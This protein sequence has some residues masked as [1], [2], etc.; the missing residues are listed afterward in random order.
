MRNMPDFHDKDS[1]LCERLHFPNIFN[2]I[3]KFTGLES[4]VLCSVMYV[5]GTLLF[6]ETAHTKHI[7]IK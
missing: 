5:Y 2:S 3:L 6:F 4:Q 1:L 7:I